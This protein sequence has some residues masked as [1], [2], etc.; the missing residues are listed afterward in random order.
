M[1]E[2]LRLAWEEWLWFKETKLHNFIWLLLS[3]TT[4]QGWRN[5]ISI[6]RARKI[7]AKRKLNVPAKSIGQIGGGK[8][9]RTGLIGNRYDPDG[10]S[11]PL[12][13]N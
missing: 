2:R 3:L 5:F 13:G 4:Q 11:Y 10:G 7:I 1:R 12:G 9:E 8:S 6:R